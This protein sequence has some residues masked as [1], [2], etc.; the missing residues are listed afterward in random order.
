MDQ[1]P[2][3][4]PD[5][6]SRQQ[7]GSAVD[8]RKTQK[9]RIDHQSA[10]PSNAEAEIGD[11]AA[12]GLEAIAGGG[13]E[14]DRIDGGAGQEDARTLPSNGQQVVRQR[15]GVNGNGDSADR[16]GAAA[17]VGEAGELRPDPDRTVP[18]DAETKIGDDAT[19]GLEAIAGGGNE[20]DRIDGGA[21]QE[22]ARTLP[23]NGQQVVRQRAGVNG[24]GDS[25]DR[26]GADAGV[27][28]AGELR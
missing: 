9:S 21:G 14:R 10:V 1:R 23:S 24:N 27:G 25:A 17:G 18:S 19:A 22:D 8:S 2:S 11:D 4:D 20:R 7:Q 16:Q 15:A 26:Q 13:N 12:A 3:V 5:R 28:E 6:V